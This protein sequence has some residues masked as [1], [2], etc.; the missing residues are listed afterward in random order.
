MNIVDALLMGSGIAIV[1]NRHVP[2]RKLDLETGEERDL[3]C[4]RI[5][6]ALHFH[7]TR[8]A[9]V[10]HVLAT[11]NRDLDRWADDGGRA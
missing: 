6:G 1:E 3:L 2:L 10:R 4:V 5:D 7:P 9:M 8:L 11:Q